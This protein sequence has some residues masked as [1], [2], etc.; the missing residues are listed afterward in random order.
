M[1]NE[2]KNLVAEYTKKAICLTSDLDFY[3]YRGQANSEWEVECSASRRIRSTLG[4]SWNDL[5]HMERLISYHE[6]V[7]LAPA[8][9]DGYGT[10]DGRELHDLELLAELQ[11]FGAATC[12][13]DFT[14]NF[15]AAL[16]FACSEE[17]TENGKVFVLS[18]NNNFR[19]LTQSYL[20]EKIRPI[21]EIVK[22]PINPSYWHWSPHGMNQRILKQDS[23]FVFGNSSIDRDHLKCILVK[24]GDKKNLLK[25]LEKLGISKKSLFKDLYGFASANRHL[26]RVPMLEASASELFLAG[27]AAYRQGDMERAIRLYT[28]AESSNYFDKASLFLNRGNA[29]FTMGKYEF[30]IADYENAEDLTPSN[31]GDNMVICISRG[32][33]KSCLGDYRGAVADMKRAAN[34]SESPLP[35]IYE[36]SVHEKEGNI[37]AMRTALENARHLAEM[38]EDDK[39]IQEIQDKLSKLPKHGE[40]PGEDTPS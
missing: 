11:H 38:A 29:Y 9:M 3:A 20:E 12:L 18:I 19:A 5:P 27:S 15:L 4:R 39:L 37:T 1:P 28:D 21:M 7:L 40:P 2:E 14:T 30:A 25:E 35:Y 22:D 34:F 10:K 36:A 23:L 32:N 24:K 16:W 13:I 31:D 33:A 17:A 8:R 6:D 26:D